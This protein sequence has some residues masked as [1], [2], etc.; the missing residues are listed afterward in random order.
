MEPILLTP[1]LISLLVTLL[2]LPFWIFRSKKAGLK[3]RDMNKFK[4]TNIAES[5]G[6]IVIAGFLIGLLCYIAIK[7]FF[8]KSSENLIEIFALISSITIISFIGFIDDLLGWK[9]GIGKKSRIALILIGAIPLVVINAGESFVGIPFMDGIDLSILFPLI[10]IPLG[11]I[12]S[13]VGFNFL[14]GFNGL[15]A[16]QG[17]IIL[18]FL[19]Y[20]AY[21]TGSSWLSIIAL[22]MVVPLLAFLLFN[23]YPAK[24]FPGD[25]LTYSVGALIAIMAILGNFEKIAMFVFFLYFVEVGLKLRGGLKKQSF[26]NPNK[27][28]SLNLP[29]SKIYGVT[30]LSI[31]ILSK[32]KKKVYEKDV[33]YLIFAF[34]IGICLLALWIFKDGLYLT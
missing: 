18:S 26:G 33:V 12:G 6:V 19:S 25:V 24:V 13:T 31:L 4:R 32:F 23:K 16:G 10:I 29:Y 9:I 15:E 3:G 2:V 20:V 30:H 11:I 17:I 28:N 1:L 21:I 7:T 8:F 34:Q 27:D 22:C 5:G 14:A